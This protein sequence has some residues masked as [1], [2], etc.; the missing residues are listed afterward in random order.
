MPLIDL[1]FLSVLAAGDAVNFKSAALG[2]QGKQRAQ[3][4]GA[5]T[6]VSH[7]RNLFPIFARR[8]AKF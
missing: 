2:R 6:C 4:F 8:L 7:I 3:H 1:E 5:R